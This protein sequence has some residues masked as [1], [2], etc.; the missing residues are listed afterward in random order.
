MDQPLW[1]DS[2]DPLLAEADAFLLDQFGTLHD[3]IALYPGVAAAMARLKA[4]GKHLVILSNSGKRSAQ[5][6]ARLAAI[7]LPPGTYDG[8]L[9]SGEV[10]WQTIARRGLPGLADAQSC[11]V[12]SRGPDREALGGLDLER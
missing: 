3:G 10:A 8:F 6:I 1:L 7:G 11:L 2:L 5:N 9:S 4:A 12:L